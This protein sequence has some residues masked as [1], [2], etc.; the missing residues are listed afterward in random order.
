MPLDLDNI[1]IEFK[2]PKC[3]FINKVRLKQVRLGEVII[4]SGCHENIRLVDKDA[5]TQRAIEGIE[6]SFKDLE[7]TIEKINRRR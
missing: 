5:S 2:C 1:E 7:R 4:C 6:K 3:G